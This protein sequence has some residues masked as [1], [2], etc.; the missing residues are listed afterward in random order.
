MAGNFTENVTSKVGG[1]VF[2]KIAQINL[3]TS[4]SASFICSLL[5]IGINVLFIWAVSKTNRKKSLLSDLYLML[6]MSDL[7]FGFVSLPMH[8]ILLTDYING[9][10]SPNTIQAQMFICY[11]FS[12]MAMTGISAITLELYLAVT[13]PL[14]Y[15]ARKQK[16]T[17]GYFLLACWFVIIF[18][19]I[20]SYLVN[21][22]F[23]HES[24]KL[25]TAAYGVS[26]LIFM[27]ICQLRIHVYLRTSQHRHNVRNKKAA[28]VALMTLL[29]Y[30]ACFLPGGI[31]SYLSSHVYRDSNFRA[32]IVD[33]WIYL[34]AISNSFF[35][36]IVYGFRS[37]RLMFPE[38]L[39]T[40]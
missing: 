10:S 32:A 27:G 30:L 1:I 19:A 23:Y 18:F 21:R 34:I 38:F 40:C 35:D 28:K 31:N 16:N 5:I 29:V 17:L 26:I 33:P 2:N 39:K 13:K 4:T 12:T 20:I 25:T 36:T 3:I 15:V 6:S 11:L 7:L 8:V 24:Y 9:I 14:T 22:S 37:K